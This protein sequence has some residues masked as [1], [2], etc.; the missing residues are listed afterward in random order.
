[1]KPEK[2]KKTPPE[3]LQRTF[4]SRTVHI[5]YTQTHATLGTKWKKL[6]M[7][8]HGA[9]RMIMWLEVRLAAVAAATAAA[10]RPP[11]LPQMWQTAQPFSV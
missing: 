6:F 4:R 9:V 2:A 8:W 7:R 10:S 3:A 5:L 1:M 11:D